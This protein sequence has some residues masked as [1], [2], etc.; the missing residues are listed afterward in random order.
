MKQNFLVRNT[1]IDIIR[2]IGILSI[3]LGHACNS[4]VFYSPIADSIRKF[5]YIFQIVIFF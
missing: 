1:H 4:D 5:V 3:V 2:R